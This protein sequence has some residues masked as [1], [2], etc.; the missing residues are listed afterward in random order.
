MAHR[1][2]R[3]HVFPCTGKSCGA[4]HGEALAK[5]FKELLPDRKD[6]RIRISAS[7]C[8]G[9]CAIG[10]NVAVYPEGV[11]YHGVELADVDAIVEEH[12]RRGRPIERLIQEPETGRSTSD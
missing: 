8:Q 4:D 7:R 5:R 9:M 6:L 12:L 3:Y 11:V 2:F 1:P 10:P